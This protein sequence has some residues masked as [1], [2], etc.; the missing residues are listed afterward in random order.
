VRILIT[1]SR[2]WADRKVMERAIW[3]HTQEL[4][5]RDVVIIHGG[6]VGADRMAEEI[7]KEWG[8]LPVTVPALWAEEG[9]SAGPIRNQ[10]MIDTYKP[11]L[12][13]AFPCDKSKGTWDCMRRAER[14]GIKVV[15]YGHPGS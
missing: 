15:N 6:A 2:C 1:G 8:F 3:E 12:C 14:A 9:R 10:K 5:P 4:N 13:L 11:E 7:A